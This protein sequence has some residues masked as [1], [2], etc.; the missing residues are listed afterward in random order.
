MFISMPIH[1]QV[2][3]QLAHIALF[4]L[5]DLDMLILARCAP[6]QSWLNPIERTFA[7]MN[8]G[9]QNVSLMRL[10]GSEE[11]EGISSIAIF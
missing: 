2:K 8:I 5:L 4:V 10:Q 3:V 11:L 9:L 1:L 7:T 6:G